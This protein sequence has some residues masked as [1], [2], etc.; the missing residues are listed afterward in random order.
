MNL[1]KRITGMCRSIPNV[2]ENLDLRPSQSPG[3]FRFGL[4]P[5]FQS[6]WV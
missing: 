5:N 6:R 1:S 4:K 2:I 3:S